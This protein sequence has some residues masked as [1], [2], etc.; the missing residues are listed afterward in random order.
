VF[1]TVDV[2]VATTVVLFVLVV[3][4]VVLVVVAFV[5]EADTAGANDVV[6]QVQL[7]G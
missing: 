2:F 4:T 5:T 7:F 6:T 3:T 1:A